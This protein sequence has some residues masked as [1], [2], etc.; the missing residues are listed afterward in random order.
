MPSWT[1]E[2]HFQSSE[3][4][5]SHS[6]SPS[7]RDLVVP[8]S[9]Q[10]RFS[11][12]VVL[13][14][15]DCTDPV[16]L[17]STSYLPLS[18]AHGFCRS[19]WHLDG[20]LVSSAVARRAVNIWMD[21]FAMLHHGAAQSLPSAFVCP[22]CPGSH[23]RMGQFQQVVEAMQQQLVPIPF[24]ASLQDMWTSASRGSAFVETW[25]LHSLF[26]PVCIRSR[27][28]RVFAHT[29]A[30]DFQLACHHTWADRM[31][32]HAEIA[33]YVV[34]PA[35][36]TFRHTV[37]HVIIVQAEQA[38]H[39]CAL[40]HCESFASF[41]IAAPHRAVLTQQGQTV[42]DV[43]RTAQHPD[44]HPSAVAQCRLVQVPFQDPIYSMFD[45]VPRLRGALLQGFVLPAEDLASDTLT[46]SSVSSGAL[47]STHLPS[48]ESV[49]DDPLELED[50]A[51]PQFLPN[52]D[53]GLVQDSDSVS[54]MHLS[55]TS[56][57]RSAGASSSAIDFDAVTFL[58][59]LDFPFHGFDQ[60]VSRV[61]DQLCCAP[62]DSPA[63]LAITYGLGLTSLGRRD[64]TFNAHDLRSLP[65]VLQNLWQDAL[66]QGDL[67]IWYV[68]RQPLLQMRRPYLVFIVTVDLKAYDFSPSSVPVLLQLESMDL[69]P[70]SRPIYAARL[71]SR[72][73]RSDILR[74]WNLEDVCQP[75]GLRSVALTC[76][77][78]AIDSDA[79]FLLRSGDLRFLRVGPFPTATRALQ[80][81]VG[82]VEDFHVAVH[83]ATLHY[84]PDDRLLCVRLH[85][86]SPANQ[87]LGHRDVYLPAT[88]VFD[89]SW[90]PQVFHAWPYQTRH[91]RLDFV[92][93]E[94]VTRP[95]NVHVAGI[96]HFTLSYVDELGPVAIL[97]EQTASSPHTDVSQ[98]EYWAIRVPCHAHTSQI[99]NFLM[100]GPFWMFP[101]TPNF[102]WH[103]DAVLMDGARNWAAG[104]LY[105]IRRIVDD[106][107]DITALLMQI[108]ARDELHHHHD[109]LSMLQLPGVSPS[110]SSTWSGSDSAVD[111]GAGDDSHVPSWVPTVTDF[112]SPS[113]N[114][115]VLPVDSGLLSLD[116]AI[117]DLCS[118]PWPGLNCDFTQLPP[119][120]PAAMYAVSVTPSACHLFQEYHCYTDGSAGDGCASWAFVLL[121]VSGA[122]ADRQFYKIGFAG[123]LL[124]HDLL[125][126]S[127]TSLDAEATAI[128]ALAEFLLA[129]QWP[130][131][132]KIVCHFDASAVGFGSFGHQR[133]VQK[134]GAF[135]PRQHAARV[136]IAMAQR[137]FALEPRHVHAH[138]YC[139]WNE[140]VDSVAGHVRLGWQPVLPGVLRSQA[141][142]AHPLRDWAWLQ[143]APDAA[144]PSLDV[145]LRN[146]PPVPDELYDR[147]M[148]VDAC[149]DI[150]TL[151]E[152]VPSFDWNVD[153]NR[154]WALLRDQ[155]QT[156][157]VRW[158]PRKR[159][160]RR[161]LYFST[162]CWNLVCDH[163]DAKI[164]LR[165]CQQ[166]ALAAK[167]RLALHTWRARLGKPSRAHLPDLQYSLQCAHMQVAH[168]LQDLASVS[169]WLDLRAYAPCLKKRIRRA[170]VAHLQRVSVLVALQRHAQFQDEVFQDVGWRP[171]PEAPLE[172]TSHPCPDCQATFATPAA[173]AVH[174][175]KRHGL[176]IATRR[177][178][179][180]GTCRI[181]Q[182][183]FHTR[184]RMLLHLQSS[185]A[186]CWVPMMRHFRPLTDD[187]AAQLDAADRAAQVALHQRGVL[188]AH[189][190]H[191]W[192][193]ATPA[194]LQGGLPMRE[195]VEHWDWS[196]PSADELQCWGGLGMLPPGRGGRDLTTRSL[197]DGRVENV[198][199]ELRSFEPSH[200]VRV[201]QWE[202][203][204][205]WVPRPFSAGNKFVV[206]LDTGAMQ[207]WAP[208]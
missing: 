180:D 199:A 34:Q 172:S 135:A 206:I 96:F 190:D 88:H 49:L 134:H 157:A 95:E 160:Q 63:W 208:G 31:D 84:P 191:V 159:R 155:L 74:E 83:Q 69:P 163:K 38:H 64:A 75:L 93:A 179:V 193:M 54:M 144:L 94:M 188:R 177:F 101:N 204:Y 164:H 1:S 169:H 10:V 139:P 154:H 198:M 196:M 143:I 137:R 73:F 207:I 77:V 171:P 79:P 153:V 13:V 57:A 115:S 76:G 78:T 16:G 19:L 185:S 6:E 42:L 194:E 110:A 116:Q 184:P 142:L 103:Q 5:S 26:S 170:E 3:D 205:D 35:P 70:H 126:F 109:T 197:T 119:L 30:E 52:A 132:T 47:L 24:W 121:G 183:H 107:S 44:M 162:P 122:G 140:F 136:L 87:P 22:L 203:H 11:E 97:I 4:L 91:Q 14:L 92:F 41:P 175:S 28:F 72:Q 61:R 15:W 156:Q 195:P 81:F 67:A 108:H 71:E 85:G 20:Q 59:G 9:K 25:Y 82:S 130:A 128:I 181:C 158:F 8:T 113:H 118:S 176:R 201:Q 66:P 125:P 161:Q 138:D 48:D 7:V 45:L 23:R 146:A 102:L 106:V 86:V 32:P 192:R 200:R 187:Q 173:L 151:L 89:L 152:S 117:S 131:A 114:P 27:R 127:P 53:S 186:G 65:D 202:V 182:R 12:D 168:Q 124:T 18:K 166:V 58:A 33:F 165:Q 29:T 56:R 104:D 178:A 99:V 51:S 112:G 37:M 39:G 189:S 150:P 148:A 2:L 40:L 133:V 17:E 68:R 60:V 141:L 46:P 100:H 120:H 129:C 147:D 167:R 111:I 21:Q 55:G 123:G 105:E 174:A 149:H 80:P 145:L 90:L 50:A 62:D 43:F 36:L 98:Q